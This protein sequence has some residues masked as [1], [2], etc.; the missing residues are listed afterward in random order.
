MVQ[1]LSY[2]TSKSGD[3]GLIPDLGTK[4][5]HVLWHGQKIKKKIFFL[6]NKRSSESS[7]TIP[8]CEDI[9]RRYSVK[10]KKLSLDT[11]SASTLLLEFPASRT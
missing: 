2:H 10:Q 8:P 4:I 3:M 6:I 1:W 9:A 7:F 11:E 5:P